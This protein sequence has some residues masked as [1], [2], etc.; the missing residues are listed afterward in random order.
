MFHQF[1]KKKRFFKRITIYNTKFSCP[2]NLKLHI[3]PLKKRK[4]SLSQIICKHMFLV[5]IHTQQS[6]MQL[7]IFHFLRKMFAPSNKDYIA[8]ALLMF[9]LFI[10][11]VNK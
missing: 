2:H 6:T 10:L 11:E 7:Q 9:G 3:V 1:M 8:S 4:R 5:G